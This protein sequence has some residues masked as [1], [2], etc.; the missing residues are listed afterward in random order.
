LSLNAQ[1]GTPEQVSDLL[2]SEI[3]R[4]AEVIARAKLEKQ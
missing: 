4:W 2:A 3:K 1:G